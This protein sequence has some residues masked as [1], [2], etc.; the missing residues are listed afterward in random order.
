M[1]VEGLTHRVV[2]AREHWRESHVTDALD[3]DL[4]ITLDG[5]LTSG[6]DFR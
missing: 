3:G 1:T 4:A 2:G 6:R 5:D